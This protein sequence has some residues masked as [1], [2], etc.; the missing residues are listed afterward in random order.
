[1]KNKFKYIVLS[2]FAISALISCIDDDN[3]A[4]TGG[5]TTGGLVNVANPLI[6]YVVGSGTTYA[7]SGSVY[8]GNV[9]TSSIEIYNTFTN[10]LTGIVSNTVLLKTV[11]ISDTNIGTTV[12]FNFTFTYDELIAGLTIDG[13]PLPANDG[14]LN[15]GD[16]WSL[17]YKSTTSTGNSNNNASTTKVAVGTRYA[18]V[19]SVVGSAYWNSGSLIG[20]DWNGTDRIIESVNAT[21]YRHKGLAYW[22]DNEYYFTVDNTTGVITVLE[23]DPDGDAILLN[24]SPIMTCAGGLFESIPCDDT[25]SVAL[26]NDITGEDELLLTVGYFRGTGATREFFEHL[27][28]KVD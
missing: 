23:T 16:F 7:A 4:L 25:T 19:Y 3:D 18:G 14:G 1:M 11:S 10:S 28:K 20:G 22:D 2:L 9:Q 5:A 8:Q 6:S 12:A 21:I 17:S 15:I 26:P 24:G 27:V 13:S